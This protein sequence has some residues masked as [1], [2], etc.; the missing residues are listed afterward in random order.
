MEDNIFIGLMTGTSV[1]SLDCAAINCKGEE[2][3]ILG[4]RNFDIPKHLKKE[5]LE[6]SIRSEINKSSLSL[7]DRELG[8]FFCD[9]I[10]AFLALISIDV[11]TVEAIGSHGQT[12]KHEPKSRNPFS[13]QIGDPQLVSDNLGITTVGHFRND[14]IAAGGQGAPLSPVFHNEVFNTRKENRI[15]INIGGIT[16]ISLLGDDKLIG[17][18]TGPGN[19]LMDS[20][21]R[22]NGKGNYDQDGKWAKSGNIIQSLLDNMMN[23]KY[24][25]LDYPKSTGPDYFSLT[26]LETHLKN[27]NKELEPKDVQATLAEM[28]AQSLL[29]SLNKLNVI[30]D[31]IYFC[32]GGVHN[33]YLLERISRGLNKK[34]KTTQEI[35]FDPDYLEAICFAWLAK[36]R[37]DE[38]KFELEEITGSK[39]AVYL[40]RIFS[41]SI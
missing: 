20:W 17:F 10:N 18:D 22:K 39:G 1:D 37:L 27:I 24:F 7:L 32:G 9:S 31:E 2:I 40:G 38:V 25:L 15:I 30:E 8:E 41:P 23:D 26:W 5:I 4:L 35:G 19:C 29:N 11:S 13:L 6:L 3:E 21:N 12:I 33:K 34:C 16:N 14:D 36:K 28:T